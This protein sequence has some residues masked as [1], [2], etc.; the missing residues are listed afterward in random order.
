MDRVVA[1]SN[2]LISAILRGGKPRDLLN[3]A[4]TGEIDLALSE[5]ILAETLRVLRV[6]FPAYARG[7]PGR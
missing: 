3:L 7:D 4:R 6:K 1:D 2:I 5:D